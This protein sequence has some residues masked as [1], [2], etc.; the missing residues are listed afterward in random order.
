M[1]P[2]VLGSKPLHDIIEVLLDNCALDRGRTV[3]FLA[4]LQ[5]VIHTL[6]SLIHPPALGKENAGVC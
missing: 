2:E 4:S 3:T 5:H 1:R 6:E